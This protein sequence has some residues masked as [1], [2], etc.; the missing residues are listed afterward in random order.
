MS[1]CDR[2]STHTSVPSHAEGGGEDWVYL[3]FIGADDAVP[4]TM[5]KCIL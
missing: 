3:C 4:S 1:M 5:K 2:D